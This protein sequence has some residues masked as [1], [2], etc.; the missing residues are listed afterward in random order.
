MRRVVFICLGS[1]LVLGLIG[2]DI[3]GRA[4]GNF[5][6]SPGHSAR[7]VVPPGEPNV[8]PPGLT[9]KRPGNVLKGLPFGLSKRRGD[10]AFPPGVARGKPNHGQ[11]VSRWAHKATA[12]GLSGQAH[13]RFVSSVAE[14]HAAIG[15]D[16]DMQAALDA[17]L[18]AAGE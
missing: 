2:W 8:L 16:C 7:R 18:K 6:Q 14:D 4:R 11:C 13:G 10:K 17:A 9:K 15:A 3:D 5:V 12:R 1:A